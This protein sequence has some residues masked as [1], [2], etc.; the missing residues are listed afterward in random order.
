MKLSTQRK[1]NLI[2]YMI[3]ITISLLITV[4][5]IGIV[6][7]QSNPQNYLKIKGKILKGYFADIDVFCYIH[8]SEEWHKINSKSNKSN[9]SIRLDPKSNYQIYFTSNQGQT[10][11]LHVDAGH[12]GMWI[13]EIDVDFDQGYMVHAKISQTDNRNDYIISSVSAG[14]NNTALI[15]EIVSGKQ[16]ELLTLTKNQEQ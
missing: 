6:S 1:N 11:V 2:S 5:S 7:G 12:S 14:Y 10:K 15:I 13:K 8:N 9:Y 3:M 4:L 16:K